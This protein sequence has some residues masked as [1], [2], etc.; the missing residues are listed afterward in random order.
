MGSGARGMRLRFMENRR[1]PSNCWGGKRSIRAPRRSSARRGTGSRNILAGMG[2]N[3]APDLRRCRILHR[4]RCSV[5]SILLI[6]TVIGCKSEPKRRDR[7]A[8]ANAGVNIIPEAILASEKIP[9]ST[10]PTDDSRPD[11]ISVLSRSPQ[12]H[13]QVLRALRM[14]GLATTLRE[15]GPYT[16]FAPT[17]EAFAKLPPGTLDR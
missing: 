2:V 4:M 11:L 7:S 3:T 6:A 15:Q 12:H 13:E 16:L 8:D 10:Q 9:P 17:D 5:V 14:S 1:A